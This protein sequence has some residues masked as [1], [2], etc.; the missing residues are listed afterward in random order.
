MQRTIDNINE[1]SVS[2]WFKI[3]NLNGGGNMLTQNNPINCT[4]V[5]YAAEY[6]FS[7][8]AIN[9]GFSNGNCS[10]VGSNSIT[11][12][13]TTTI[14]NSWH[15]RIFTLS[16]LGEAKEYIDGILV[17]SNKIGSFN[18]CVVTN[19]SLRI[20]G[21][22]WNSDYEYFNGQLDDIGLWNKVLTPQEITQLYTST[23]YN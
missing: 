12:F 4:N 2:I 7:S 11:S 20:G 16:K 3:T 19:S 8:N 5:N 17:S 9:S 15:N 13:I 21:P 22:W 1:L 18:W 6:L 14:F 10:N 23:N